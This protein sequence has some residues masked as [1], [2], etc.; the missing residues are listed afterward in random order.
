MAGSA[1]GP[2]STARRGG[3]AP[4]KGEHPQVQGGAFELVDQA[5]TVE[6]ETLFT[7]RGKPYTIPVSFNVEQGL[8][9]LHLSR[10]KDQGYA[11]DWAMEAALGTDGYAALRSVQGLESKV[12]ESMMQLIATRMLSAG[13]GPDDPKA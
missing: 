5:R 3:A 13:T 11:V 6:R 2:R 10:V 1:A 9:Y 8:E 4:V 12:L 7:Y